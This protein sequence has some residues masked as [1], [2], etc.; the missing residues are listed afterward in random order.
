[1]K[2]ISRRGLIKTFC[3][4]PLL[5]CLPKTGSAQGLPDL[6]QL[7][8]GYARRLKTILGAGKLPYIDIESS[9]NS[10]RVDIDAIAR[11]IERLDIG[12]MALSAD[13]GEGRFRKGVRFDNLSERLLAKYPDRFIPVGNGGQPPALTEGPD[14]VLEAP[15]DPPGP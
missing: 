13:I 8:A 6:A 10:T 4:L 3:A 1:M 14:E 5:A 7:K 12:L 2:T 11:S 15:G 9:C